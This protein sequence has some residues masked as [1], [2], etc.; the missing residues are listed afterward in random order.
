MKIAVVGCLHG[1]LDK[2]YEDVSLI[3]KQKKITVDLIVVCGDFQSVRNNHD[4]ECM[5]V[6]PKYRSLG[7]FHDY[8]YGKKKASVLTLFVGGNH[9]A[10]NYLLTLPY[11]GWV[12]ENIYYM[13]Y[14]SVVKFGGLRIGGVSGIYKHHDASFGHFERLPFDNSTLRSVFH[15]RELEAYRM[16]LLN[17]VHPQTQ[18]RLETNILDIMMTHDWPLNIHNNGNIAQLLKMK[19]FFREDVQR[20]QLGNTLYQSLVNDL[21]PRYWFSAHLHVR[22]EAFVD[23]GNGVNTKFLALDKC[24]P[25]RKYLEV[26]DIEPQVEEEKVLSYDPEWLAILK[27]TD[28]YMS[29]E[30]NPVKRCG[31]LWI[32]PNRLSQEEIEAAKSIF[33]S[34]LRIPRDFSPCP[35]ALIDKDIN[36]ARNINF[37]NPLTKS[38]CDKLGVT[39]PMDKIVNGVKPIS[40]P[41]E[42]NLDEDE[43]DVTEETFEEAVAKKMK[44]EAEEQLAAGQLFVI[45][46]Q[47]TH[48][49]V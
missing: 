8:Y 38:F 22:F 42:I 12:C 13:G 31:P 14:S 6:P 35:P 18:E 11:G 24:L 48:A 10:S 3:E 39:D 44:S 47:G 49:C 9:E 23:F 5:A 21:K 43:D 46:T 1:E 32:V 41:D 27:H 28:M 29:T 26:I 34:D 16:K 19:P 17:G 2:V 36:P 4:L 40:N 37:I 30:K 45:D 20:G 25:K 33:G 7:Q 15:T